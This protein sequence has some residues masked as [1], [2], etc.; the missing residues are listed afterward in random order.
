MNKSQISGV[1][2]LS[3]QKAKVAPT[4]KNFGKIV[5]L[6]VLLT[7]YFCYPFFF[8]IQSKVKNNYREIY[9]IDAHNL[10]LWMWEVPSYFHYQ[11]FFQNFFHFGGFSIK[12]FSQIFYKN[13]LRQL[14]QQLRVLKQI[15]TSLFQEEV[16]ENFPPAIQKKTFNST[17]SK[18][19]KSVRSPGVFV[20]NFSNF[21]FFNPI[22]LLTALKN[23]FKVKNSRKSS[24][25]IFGA[26]NAHSVDVKKSKLFPLKIIVQDLFNFGGFLAKL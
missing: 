7:R 8:I 23:W 20:K 21:A 25:S 4:T 6:S 22:L 17:T 19:F 14:L 24:I 1:F 16:E 13:E 18:I 9:R 3:D 10:N 2:Q 26:K 12:L 15:S 11:E 5:E